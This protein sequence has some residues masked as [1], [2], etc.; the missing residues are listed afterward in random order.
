[1]E[2]SFGNETLFHNILID[3][4][5][6]CNALKT[7]EYFKSISIKIKCKYSSFI[8][9]LKCNSFGITQSAF[10]PWNCETFGWW[11]KVETKS[12]RTEKN[13][14]FKRIKR[15]DLCIFIPIAKT[16]NSSFIIPIYESAAANDLKTINCTKHLCDH[17]ICLHFVLNKQTTTTTKHTHFRS[18][19]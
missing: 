16:L 1:M 17:V 4:I 11:L 14:L 9:L 12:K 7:S 15:K 3:W 6:N 8:K 19:K 18:W 10:L 13:S 5:E 2:I